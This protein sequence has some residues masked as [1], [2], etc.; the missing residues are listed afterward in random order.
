MTAA[1]LADAGVATLRR[2][3][4][5]RNRALD[6]VALTDLIA[7]GRPVI[8]KAG[9]AHWPLVQA[10]LQSPDVAADILKAQ[11]SGNPVVAYIGDPAI[12]GRYHYNSALTALNF[13]TERGVLSAFVDRLLALRNQPCPPSLYIGS[14]D[15]DI[16]LPG[17]RAQHE[18]RLGDD[19]FD[20]HRAVASIWIGNRT[21]APTH[22]DMSNNLAICVAGH[23]R[24]TLFPPDQTS[25]LYPGPIDP[26]PAGQIVSMV[27][28]AAP[29]FER[30]PRFAQALQAG[31]V[32]EL[33]PGD[34]LIY[35]A[36][37]WHQVEALDDFN[38]LI[39]YWWNETPD[40]LDDPMTTLLHALLSLRD[41]PAHE[42]E[43]WRHIFDHYVF[44]PAETAAAHLPPHARGPLAPL[45]QM[46]AR[47]LRA[48]VSNKIN[49]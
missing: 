26:T 32:A 5:I 22:W 48:L 10:G 33:E 28:P 30:Y 27:D 11:D 12:K 45:D 19:T 24:F 17:L 41:R 42:K 29:D 1:E 38:V 7:A 21:V 31:E 44:G 37:W 49:R 16:H 15:L 14:T 36:L 18:V 47:R 25:N 20:R 39:N 2:T 6:Q 8:L 9:A 13:S 35:P 40:F 43:A 23:R 4:E 34:V 3:D 46:L